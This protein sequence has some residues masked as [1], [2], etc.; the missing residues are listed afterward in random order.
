MSHGV[1]FA[2]CQEVTELSSLKSRNSPYHEHVCRVNTIHIPQNP[3]HIP[4]YQPQ[5]QHFGSWT[6][7]SPTSKMTSHGPVSALGHSEN[8]GLGHIPAIATW[9]GCGG[10]ATPTLL[11]NF[12]PKLCPQTLSIL[13]L[14]VG[15]CFHVESQN[16]ARFH[17]R[18]ETEAFHLEFGIVTAVGLQSWVD[19]FHGITSKILHVTF[20]RYQSSL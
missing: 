13:F 10:R 12:V 17:G 3:I 18:Y 6:H 8:P 2:N 16:V 1:Q 4:L 11:A 20:M 14:S 9:W 7:H 15:C 19:V 5:I